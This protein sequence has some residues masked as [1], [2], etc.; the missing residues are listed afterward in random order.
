MRVVYMLLTEGF[1]DWEA[2]L[3]AAEINKSD[4]FR[5]STVTL[6]GDS[7]VSMGGLRVMPDLSASELNLR[8]AALLLVPGGTVWEEEDQPYAV[9]LVRSAVASRVPVGALCGAT[10]ALAR[11]GLLQDRK[12]TSNHPGYLEKFVEEYESDGRYVDAPAVRDRGVISAS[13]MGSVEFAYEVI[14]LLDLYPKEMQPVWL[15]IHQE[16]RVPEDAL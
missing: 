7:V 6:D 12:H 16:K 11:A 10:I 5:I 2:S 8:D 13:A 14:Q 4:T 3:A 15:S 9:S 1:A